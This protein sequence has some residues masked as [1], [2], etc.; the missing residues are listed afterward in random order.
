MKLALSLALVGAAMLGAQPKP[1]LTPKDYGQFENLGPLTLSP[2]GKWL[3]YAVNRSSR[4]NELRITDVAGASTK[5]VAFGEQ[6]VFSADSKWVAYALGA[7]EAAQDKLR[8]DK[9][10]YHR[11]LG[12]MELATG[13]MS[14]IEGISAFTFSP[15]GAFLA[16]RKYP[17][18]KAPAA[19]PTPDAPAS[20]ETPT[21]ATL[22]VRALATGRDT[23]F[24]NVN[25]FAWQDVPKSGKLLALA[26]GSED[27]TGNG[28]QLFDAETGTLRVLDSSL[29]SYSGLAWRKKSADLAVLK[30]ITDEKRDGPANS[31]LAWT[32]VGEPSETARVYEPK[33]LPTGQRI[34]P[35]RKPS[36]AEGSPVVFVG[37]GKWD[38]KLELKKDEPELPGVDVWHWRDA[39]V[40]PRQKIAARNDRQRN[41]LAA[42]NVESGKL[43]TL[44]HGNEEQVRP[45]K[46]GKT[47]YVDDWS[48]YTMQRSIGRPAGDV[49]LVDLA[50][51]ERTQIRK[52]LSDDEYLRAS[53]AGKYL[54]YFESNH[55][56]T[57]N[58]ATR[59]VVDITKGI[60]SQ[61]ANLESDETVKQKPPFGVGGWTQDDGAV[62]LFDKFD[63][64]KVAPD[65]TGATKLTNGAKDQ[66]RHRV[67]AGLNPEVDY[68][69]GSIYAQMFGIWNKKSGYA[70]ISLDGKETRLILADRSV[71]R[72][73]K[74]KDADVYAYSTETFEESP[75]AFVGG[76][77][78]KDAKQVSKLNPFFANFAWGRSEL[79]EYKNAAGERLQGTLYYPA[80][81]EPGK[82]YPMVVYMYEKLSDGLHAFRMP[83]ERDYYNPQPFVQNG[84]LFLNPDITFRPREPGLSVTDCVGAAVKKVI[85]MG[86]ADAAKA[87]TV[88]HSWGGFDST[89]LATHSKM[90]AASVAGAP[91]TNLVS[92]YGN[93][94]WSQG[95]AE[96]DHIETGQQRMEV[97]LYEDLQ[98]YIRN[99]ALFNVQNM[100]TPLLIEVGDADGTV[101][102]HQGVEL[103]N[104]ARR[105]GKNVVL[106]VYAGEDHGLRKKPNQ[107][108]YQQKILAWFGHYLKGEPAQQWITE[109][110]P[111]LQHQDEL[112]RLKALGQ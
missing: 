110:E 51:G 86:V 29:S 64:W 25:E 40:I 60:P 76:A 67:V 88:G 12:L 100:T 50:T 33:G 63:I 3:A 108:D 69:Q 18:E 97:P 80:N 73:V 92:N 55:Y 36:W 79:I 78:L 109:G 16:M 21:L 32:Q 104:V 112:K 37:I 48:A 111:F 85:E 91:I 61:F 84:Y 22:I 24:G 7:S 71:G 99:S 19:T 53:P 38:D 83:S 8:K 56:W 14:T 17:A 81:Y 77:N 20:D 43:A 103:Y 11:K 96:T 15:N 41:L 5:A 2:D 75:Q 39:S 72:L 94:H 30:S 49:S 70:R 93:H 27:K 65:G 1:L 82:K 4:D 47:G 52:C 105:A 9:K 59:A 101:F 102:F 13:K 42:W 31:V 10:P 95:I 58:T 68:V 45:F 23:T 26:I 34:V 90:F 66:I 54:L 107:M 46:N 6:P 74:A 89:F 57:I 28:L 44:G 35:F 98:A 87:G 62:L 106:I